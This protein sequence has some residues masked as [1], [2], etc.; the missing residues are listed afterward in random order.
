MTSYGAPNNTFHPASGIPSHLPQQLPK[1]IP[2]ASRYPPAYSVARERLK[3]LGRAHSHEGVTS[4]MNLQITPSTYY[5]P[6]IIVT[7]GI[8]CS[9]N[10]TDD[11]GNSNNYN[12]EN[13]R[14]LALN[15]INNY[16]FPYFDSSILYGY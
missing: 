11:N 14:I 6:N 4:S 5:Q 12:Y 2:T 15:L 10:D 3:I 9:D 13:C 16:R 8:P 1:N 7:G